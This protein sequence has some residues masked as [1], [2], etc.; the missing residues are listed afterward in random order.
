MSD[1]NVN[2]VQ[3][4]FARFAPGDLDEWAELWHPDCVSTPAEGW[5]EP[6]PFVGREAIRRQFD[7]LF[8]DLS[9]FEVDEVRVIADSDDWVVATWGMRGRG[10]GSGL[11]IRMEG[12]TAYRFRDGLVSEGHFRWSED[13]ALRAAGFLE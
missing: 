9:E 8:A 1:Q 3:A 7:N 13:E 5:P 4:L 11:E 6:G 12:A 10:A 2:V